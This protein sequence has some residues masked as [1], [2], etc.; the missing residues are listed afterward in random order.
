LSVR[1]TLNGLRW[2]A[3][4]VVYLTFS[5]WVH[6]A[7]GIGRLE[8]PAAVVLLPLEVAF[9]IWTGWVLS[10]KRI[11]WRDLIPFGIIGAALGSIYSVGA[12]VY[13]PHLFST[14]ATRYGV[15]GAVFAMISTLFCIMVVL[16]ASAALGREVHEEL[17]RIRRGVRPPDDEVRRQWDN[18]IAE[19]RS[20]FDV[21]R[22]QFAKRRRRRKESKTP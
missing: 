3:V 21:A 14:Y 16:V 19:A 20:R 15:I 11:P 18:V 4:L 17:D 9:L 5:G 6:G 12:T 1:N 8:L 7:L 13:V 22:E 2:L 10:A